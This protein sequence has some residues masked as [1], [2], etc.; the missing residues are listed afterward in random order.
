MYADAGVIDDIENKMR[1]MQ[2][3]KTTDDVIPQGS[4]GRIN[5]DNAE[6]QSKSWPYGLN[7][8]SYN[9][10]EK[11]MKR[12]RKL[13]EKGRE[14]QLSKLDDRRKK[15]A[16]RLTR[17]SGMIDEIL[18]SSTNAFAIKEQLNRLDDLFQI[19]GSIQKEMIILD[20]NYNDGD[21]FYQ[22]DEK[23]FSIK[24]KIHG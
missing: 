19:I 4:R 14:Y 24:Y 10:E 13:T 7:E 15:A 1:R 12:T 6:G 22:L 23:V 9:L 3:S 16:S 8:K 11:P 2:I 5:E 17:E 20:P 21:W 18:F